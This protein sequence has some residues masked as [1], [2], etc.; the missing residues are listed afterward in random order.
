MRTS[1][2]ISTISYNTEQFLTQT[3]N[4]LITNKLISFWTFIPHLPEDDEAGNKPHTHLY[5]EP[6]KLIQTED[7]REFF[8]ELDLNNPTLKPLGC[9]TFR[10]SKFA[11]WYL[12][13]I[14]DKAYL[15]SKGQARRYHYKHEDF[16]TSDADELLYRV[17]TI[18]LT[19]VS[20]YQPMLD[21]Q[22]H[23]VTWEEYLRRGTTPIQQIRQ[24][25]EA[26]FTLL[27]PSDRTY[28][29]GYE[30]HEINKYTGEIDEPSED[31]TEQEILDDAV[32]AQSYLGYL[33]YDAIP[34]QTISEDETLP[35]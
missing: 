22:A 3:L 21:A 5:C 6:C 20:P 29:N 35:L 18:D 27:S 19:Q 31:K 16:R 17:R 11:D 14:H 10:T 4:R 7:I 33:G 15:A 26:W 32:K 1:K 23:G 25:R 8:K 13:S 24:W 28:R 2:P 12:Y 34:M 30:G 9:I